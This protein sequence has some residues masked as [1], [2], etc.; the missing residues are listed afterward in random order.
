M[1]LTI[2][3]THELKGNGYLLG[4]GGENESEQLVINV[5]YDVLLDKWA[6]I[7]FEQGEDKFSTERLTVDNGQVVYN[8]PN[9]LLKQGHT[10]IQ[11]VFRDANGFVWKSFKRQF[12][13]D[14]SINAGSNLP[15]EYPDFI[16]KAQKL[17]D[18]ITVESEKVDEVLSTEEERKAA[19][20]VRAQNEATRLENETVRET[21]E[22]E[23]NT[24]ESARKTAEGQRQINETGRVDAETARRTEFSG[25]ANSLG[26]LNTYDKRLINLEEAGV[27]GLFDY[28][29]DDTTAYSKT[30]PAKALP[31]ARL[32]KV[33]GMT[34]KAD[35][36]L[37][38]TKVKSV[39]GNAIPDAIQL[40]D[41]YGLGIND[42][43]YNYI[44]F[45]RKVFV[46][47]VAVVDLGTLDFVYNQ[48]K[49]TFGVSIVDCFESNVGNSLGRSICNAYSE[50]ELIWSDLTEES[51]YVLNYGGILI[52][53]L[54]Y[55]DATTFKSA[56]QGVMFVY[57]L[58]TPI[59]TDIS[60]YLTDNYIKV[61]GSVVFENDNAQAVPSEIVNA[62]K[63]RLNVLRFRRKQQ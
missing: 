53:D 58:A 62:V 44:D 59:E 20:L 54:R 38:D 34:Y 3:K 26:N 4:V 42:A 47:K 1:I 63:R 31:Y 30:V 43:C 32:N 52:R 57:E 39:G 55:I 5:A 41:G 29:T 8:I 33:G 37:I 36:A 40:L 16:T 13:V 51:G 45:E 46:K 10:K 21:T 15:E 22:E 27:G 49:N 60:A 25:W 11:V 28:V 18:E 48:S 14:A 17:L 9:G 2:D 50:N 56:M 61:N 19:E 23:R 24:A 12:L 35:N 6:Y 7:E